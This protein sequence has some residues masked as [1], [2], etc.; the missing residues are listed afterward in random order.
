MKTWI[1]IKNGKIF[2][3]ASRE[4]NLRWVDDGVPLTE[5]EK[6]GMTVLHI[7]N[8]D[9]RVEDAINPDGSNHIKDSPQRFEEPPKTELE[10]LR[11]K[12]NEMDLKIK[13]LQER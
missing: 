9:M 7:E 8:R 5:E 3:I 4:V 1:N 13:Q 2:G 11:E 10:L 6:A 12:V